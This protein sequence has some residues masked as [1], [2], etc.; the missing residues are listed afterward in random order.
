[1]APTEGDVLQDL[2]ELQ[3]SGNAV[4]WPRCRLHEASDKASA[5]SSAVPAMTLPPDGCQQGVRSLPPVVASPELEE[6]LAELA[7]LQACGL[8]VRWPTGR[9]RL[10]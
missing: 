2:R 9:H 6:A 1:M 7:D 5:D 8:P 3:S 4:R 10:L